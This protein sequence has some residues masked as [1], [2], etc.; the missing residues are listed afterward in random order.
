MPIELLKNGQLKLPQLEHKVSLRRLKRRFDSTKAISD[1]KYEVAKLCVPVGK[2]DHIIGLFDAPFT[3]VEYGDYDCPRCAD[4]TPVVREIRRILGEDLRFVWRHFPLIS[5]YP[6]AS[7]ID[8]GISAAEAAEA[9]SVQ[10][11]FWPMHDILCEHQG[12]LDDGHL[13]Q[14]AA[15]VGLDTDRF[16]REIRQRTF[17]EWVRED[18]QSGVHSGVKGTPTFFIN[19]F[20]HDDACDFETLLLAIQ[21]SADPK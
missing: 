2:R 13:E 3:L 12:A 4:T 20:R 21:H 10:G 7:F 1:V 5:P 17:G 6:P 16:V 19:G 9:A 15:Q 8:H 14:Y 11:M 18:F